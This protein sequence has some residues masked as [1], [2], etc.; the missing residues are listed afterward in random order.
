MADEKRVVLVKPGDILLIGNTE[1]MSARDFTVAIEAF[2]KL[3]LKVIVFAD[4]INIDLVTADHVRQILEGSTD[5]AGET[6]SRPTGTDPDQPGAEVPVREPSAG[7]QSHEEE[8]WT[9]T[10]HG[11]GLGVVERNGDGGVLR[12]HGDC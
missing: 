4:D 12:D 11:T 2:K 1:I 5:E 3:R 7:P 8:T 9:G 6:R 10:G